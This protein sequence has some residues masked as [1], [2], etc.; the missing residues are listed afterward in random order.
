MKREN[1]ERGMVKKYV[2]TQAIMGDRE[3][4]GIRISQRKARWQQSFSKTATK[5]FCAEIK[6]LDQNGWSGTLVKS[7][8]YSHGLSPFFC[9]LETLLT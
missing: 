8:K 9:P 5:I 7:V 1:M 6:I 3:A 2:V 4:G